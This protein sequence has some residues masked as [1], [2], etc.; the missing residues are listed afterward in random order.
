MTESQ[1][2]IGGADSFLYFTLIIY[3]Y[4]SI[5]IVLFS[6]SQL[7]HASS[8]LEKYM[9]EALGMKKGVVRIESK[10][11]EAKSKCLVCQPGFKTLPEGK[12]ESSYN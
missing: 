7:D 1:H 6:N 8:Q 10:N 3:T 2:G 5:Q 9:A 12:A 4:F 11:H